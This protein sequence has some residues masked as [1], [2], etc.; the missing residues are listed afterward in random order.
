MCLH[1]P[2][3]GQSE[4]TDIRNNSTVE[5]E[6]VQLIAFT[7][8]PNNKVSAGSQMILKNLRESIIFAIIVFTKSFFV[9]L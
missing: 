5:G 1:H 3:L 9:I 6:D 4:K 2:H 8:D 7:E